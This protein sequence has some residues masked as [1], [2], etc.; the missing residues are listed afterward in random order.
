MKP[1]EPPP[2]T[3]H[4]NLQTKEMD[5]TNKKKCCC[6]PYPTIE[7]TRAFKNP[8]ASS[9]KEV[10]AL[11]ADVIN[12]CSQYGCFHVNIKQSA[13]AGGEKLS[14]EKVAKES[15]EKLFEESFLSSHVCGNVKSVPFQSRDGKIISTKYR[16]RAAESGG[17]SGLEPKQSWEFF[18]CHNML[19]SSSSNTASR[20]MD[21]LAILSD[22]TRILH[23][24]AACLF[25]NIL[26]FPS[27]TFIDERECQCDTQNSECYCSIDLLRA[28]KYDALTD[29]H[30]INLGSSPHTDW[31]AITVV[32]QD[33]R[34]GLQ[35]YCHEHERWND[36]EIQT[37]NG[38]DY[39]RLFLHVGDF[40][41]LA[42]CGY[43]PKDVIWPSPLHR[44]V[45]PKKTHDSSED[46]EDDA[47][48][49]LVYF[50]Y[51]PRGISLEDARSSLSPRQLDA[52]PGVVYGSNNN[53]PYD[54]FMVLKDQS[55]G[56]A[57]SHSSEEEVYNRIAKVSFDTVIE[58]K[59][60]QV[61][62]V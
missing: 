54:R 11:K 18:R 33:S 23:E 59:W 62:R 7:L 14:D 15:I 43:P 5:S 55:I 52:N 3:A 2:T 41:S 48:C 60:A 20:E 9:S 39:V 44:V 4:H 10:D 31:G 40:T 12:A 19:A 47:R 29:E 28:F 6:G 21:R 17:N 34:G 27:G 8:S 32:W 42:K 56:T 61:Q 37:D 13:I 53:F 30:E 46:K 57:T 22:F 24:V 16:G 25:S 49:S 45:C 35:I 38:G 58:E 36:V 51:P 1:N 26:D 50:V